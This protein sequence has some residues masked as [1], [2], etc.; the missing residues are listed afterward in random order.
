LDGLVLTPVVRTGA[1]TSSCALVQRPFAGMVLARRW[2]LLSVL[3]W[4][5]PLV[6]LP[7][8]EVVASAGETV[9]ATCCR[10]SDS[11]ALM[12]YCRPL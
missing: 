7:T 4:S 5:P 1:K 2:P 3:R 12:A 8:A 11:L 10:T 6:R 9:S